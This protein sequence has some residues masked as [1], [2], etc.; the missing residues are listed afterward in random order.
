MNAEWFRGE[1]GENQLFF[2]VYHYIF[3]AKGID[4]VFRAVAVEAPG[5]E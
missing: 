2:I 5:R 1:S 3:N 4:V